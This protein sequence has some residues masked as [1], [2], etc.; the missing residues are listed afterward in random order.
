MNKERQA[1]ASVYNMA[2]ANRLTDSQVVCIYLRLR[3]AG[4][5]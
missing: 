2:Y 4:K 1:I 5:I 3:K